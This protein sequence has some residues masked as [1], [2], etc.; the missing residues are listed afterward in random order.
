MTKEQSQSLCEALCE[1][2]G[3]EG[4]SFRIHVNSIA[5]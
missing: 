4:P 3:P 2:L 5:S 1:V